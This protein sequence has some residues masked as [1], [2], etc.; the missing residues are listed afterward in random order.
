M[1]DFLSID[2]NHII[3]GVE[4]CIDIVKHLPEEL[5]SCDNM[6]HDSDRIT[7]WAGIFLDPIGLVTTLTTNITVNL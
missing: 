2:I 7:Q 5:A 1:E 6:G 3:R 4:E